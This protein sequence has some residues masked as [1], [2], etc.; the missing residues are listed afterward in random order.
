MIIRIEHDTQNDCRID[1]I[2][3]T[4]LLTLLGELGI[5]SGFS[6]EGLLDRYIGLEHSR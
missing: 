4:E 3:K 2:G 5:N 6:I 1:D